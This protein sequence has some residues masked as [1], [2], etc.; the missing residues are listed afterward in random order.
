MKIICNKEN[1]PKEVMEKHEIVCDI[2]AENKFEEK[3]IKKL[4]EN[5]NSIEEHEEY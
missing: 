5:E 1:N 3:I 4:I 2:I